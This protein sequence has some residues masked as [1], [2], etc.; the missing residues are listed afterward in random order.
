MVERRDLD[1]RRLLR[2]GHPGNRVDEHRRGELDQSRNDH[3]QVLIRGGVGFEAIDRRWGRGNDFAQPG[4][5]GPDA[6]LDPQLRPVSKRRLV[7]G[8]QSVSAG[9]Q[10]R[11]TIHAGLPIRF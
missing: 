7:L 10:G 4:C 3:P 2:S 9:R 8:G 6:C 5:A 11:P 1:R